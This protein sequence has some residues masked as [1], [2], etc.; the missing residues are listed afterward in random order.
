MLLRKSFPFQSCLSLPLFFARHSSRRGL[1]QAAPAPAIMM[2][3][4]FRRFGSRKNEH[5]AMYKPTTSTGP[6]TFMRALMLPTPTELMSGNRSVLLL[7]RAIAN[8]GQQTWRAPAG[9]YASSRRPFDARRP[10]PP[11]WPSSIRPV[12]GFT[13]GQPTCQGYR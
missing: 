3:L 1:G 12:I 10:S 5:A 2:A 8:A 11:R 6:I 13:Q 7:Y 4:K 9:A